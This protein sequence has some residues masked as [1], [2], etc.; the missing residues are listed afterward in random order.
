MA[1]GSNKYIDRIKL[2]GI[3]RPQPFSHRFE[4]KL[5]FH[6]YVSEWAHFPLSVRIKEYEKLRNWRAKQ[7][8]GLAGLHNYNKR[9]KSGKSRRKTGGEHGAVVDVGGGGDN[10]GGE[11]GG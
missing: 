4:H 8:D 7:T 6:Y 1:K 5:Y 3:V 10:A 9:M 11:D 2:G